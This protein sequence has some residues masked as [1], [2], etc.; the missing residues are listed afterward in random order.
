MFKAVIFDRDGTLNKTAPKEQ[1]GYVLSADELILLPTV[2]ESMQR[3][4]EKGIERFVYTQQKGV[5][6]GLLSEET[7]DD[8]HLKLNTL[9]PEGAGITY[10][11]YCPHH[12]AGT[13]TCAKPGP[14]MID[15]IL[16]QFNLQAH[17]VLAIGDTKRDKISAEAAGV[18][19]A[20]V[21]SDDVEKHTDYSDSD[22]VFKTL[23]EALAAHGL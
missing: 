7:L 3:L 21:C 15:S 5:G 19:F 16:R 22:R 2:A 23:D 20:Y 10:F 6:K 8:I 14:G 18:A 1:G 17:E 11:A 4:A 13:C 9:L 12:I